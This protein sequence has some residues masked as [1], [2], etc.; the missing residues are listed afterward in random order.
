MPA[1]ARSPSGAN[2]R[3]CA[4]SSYLND[5]LKSLFSFGPVAAQ[6]RSRQKPSSAK[7]LREILPEPE[8]MV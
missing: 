6:E 3:P 5:G 7:S 4:A 2:I 8:K 1:A